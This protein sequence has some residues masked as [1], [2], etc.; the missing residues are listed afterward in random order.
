M[1]YPGYVCNASISEQDL[2]ALV[3]WVIE[4]VLCLARKAEI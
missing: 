1:V 3:F 4:T 2:Y